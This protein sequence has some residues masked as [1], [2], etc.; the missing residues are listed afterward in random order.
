M[1]HHVTIANVLAVWDCMMNCA[2]QATPRGELIGWDSEDIGALLEIEMAEV[3]AIHTAMQGKT[4]NGNRLTGWEKRQPKRERE[5]QTAAVRKAA[6]RWRDMDANSDATPSHTTSH[7]VTPREEERREEES[8]E[9]RAEALFV[10]KSEKIDSRTTTIEPPTPRIELGARATQAAKVLRDA[11]VVQ[12]NKSHPALIRLLH[13]GVTDAELAEAA[14][15]AAAKGKRHLPYVCGVVD[16]RRAD[17]AAT[18]MVRPKGVSK[19]IAG[20]GAHRPYEP[21][22]RIINRVNADAAQAQSMAELMATIS[23]PDTSGLPR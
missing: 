14:A 11:G 19:P 4:L 3:D 17:A 2:S 21:E 9:E 15:L 18:G 13:A 5:D 16:G 22:R 8:R 7:H 23:L 6:Q 1:S 20:S 10:G 12:V